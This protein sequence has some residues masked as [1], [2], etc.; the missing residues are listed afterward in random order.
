M[1]LTSRGVSLDLTYPQVMG[2]LNVTPDSFSDGGRHN[3]IDLALKHAQ[4]MIAAGATI[5][6]I[7]GESTR[8]G[9]AEV[10]EDEELSRVVPVVEAISQRMD[11]WIS[12]DTSKAGVILETAKAG[13]HLINDIR[14]LQEPG[15]LSA[16]ASTGLPVCLM[17]MQGQPKNMQ[18]APHYENLISEINTYFN[19]QIAR[20]VSAGI[21]KNKLLLDPGFGFGKNL[22]H[23]YQLLARLA[24]FH[25]FG[26][27]LL[28]GMS[29]KSMV[30]QLLQVPPEL[31]VT[32]SVACAVIAAMQGAQII[33][34]HDVKETVEA[35]RIVEATLSARD[36]NKS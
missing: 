18:R 12:V 36:E 34:V 7:G 8:P 1:Q 16:A 15:A 28:V 24:E 3:R 32:G 31:R 5:L 35:M 4:A 6:D 26:L 27:P 13:A 19:E 30:G 33:R 10:S 29:R 14:S 2:I 25:H 22:K 11:V 23:N 21:P 9:A 17:H 20:C